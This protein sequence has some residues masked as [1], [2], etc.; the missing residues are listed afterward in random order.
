MSGFPRECK[1]ARHA[2]PDHRLVRDLVMDHDGIEVIFHIQR[3]L[4]VD[5]KSGRHREM[6]LQITSNAI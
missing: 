2:G 5:P 6:P 4:Y 3:H 1:K